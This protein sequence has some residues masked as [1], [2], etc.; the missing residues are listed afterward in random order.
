MFIKATINGTDNEVIINTEKIL[1]ANR[2]KGHTTVHM[3]KDGAF[4]NVNETP[5][6]LLKQL[7]GSD[8]SPPKN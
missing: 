4:V 2:G 6:E 3:H 7:D 8:D 1:F 5:H